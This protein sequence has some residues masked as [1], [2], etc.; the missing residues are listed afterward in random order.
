M[1]EGTTAWGALTLL[2][3]SERRPFTPAETELVASVTTPLATGLRRALLGTPPVAAPAEG[4]SSGIAVLGPDNVL[5]LADEWAERWLAELNAERPAGRLPPVVAALAQRAR[6][7]DADHRAPCEAR[8]R[9][10][11]GAWV[12]VRASA[13]GPEPVSEVAIVLEP[14]RSRQLAPLIA[15]AYGL[16]ERERV[17]T[18]HVAHGLATDDIAARECISPWTV[19]D[20]LK[21]IFEKVGVRTRGELVARIFIEPDAARL[22]P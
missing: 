6:M 11:S 19:Q 22:A 3:Q 13:L 1:V 7:A 2:R 14:A 12:V 10:A 9:T 4:L 21:S 5:A 18:Q 20:H 8:V 15:D 16:T 17:I